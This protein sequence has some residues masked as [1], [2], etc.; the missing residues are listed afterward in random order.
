MSIS[1]S[2]QVVLNFHLP[3]NMWLFLFRLLYSVS[4]ARHIT[5]TLGYMM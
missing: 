3:T 4:V 5:L 1:K 2:F